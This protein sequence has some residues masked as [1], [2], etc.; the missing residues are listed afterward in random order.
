MKLAIFPILD[1]Q[2]ELG[3]VLN[4]FDTESHD[5]SNTLSLKTSFSIEFPNNSDLKFKL[6]RSSVNNLDKVNLT[7]MMVLV[8]C[9]PGVLDYTH[10]HISPPLVTY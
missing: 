2:Q 3:E 5:S 6:K 4:N 1:N 7:A 10:V 9:H 8:P